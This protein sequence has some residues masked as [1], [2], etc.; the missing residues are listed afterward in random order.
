MQLI[1]KRLTKRYGADL[2]TQLEHQDMT[3]LFVAVLLSPQSTDKQTNKA[4][5]RLFKK[6][7]T[8]D[9]YANADITELSKDLSGMNYYKTKAKH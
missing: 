2:T 9:D 8:F 6:Y 5:V 4:T 1:L 7:K 3:Q